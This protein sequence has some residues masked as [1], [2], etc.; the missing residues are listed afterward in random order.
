MQ[1]ELFF[2]SEAVKI[3]RT[4]SLS[5]AA[6]FLSGMVLVCGDHPAADAIRDHARAVADCDAQLRLWA[7]GQ[8]LLPLKV[9]NETNVPE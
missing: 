1:D 3:S 6:R 2:L 4:L 8:Q 9:T 7:D 5:D